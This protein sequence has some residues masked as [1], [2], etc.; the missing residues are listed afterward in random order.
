MFICDI[1][2]FNRYGKIKLDEMLY[3]LKVDWRELI[4][5][6]VIEQMS[7][8]SQAHLIPFLQ[9]DKA[10]VTKLLKSMENKGLIRREVDEQDQRNKLCYLTKQ[11]EELIPDLHESLNLWEEACFN[12]ISKEDRLQF[13]KISKIIT[14]NLLMNETFR[15]N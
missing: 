6:L 1:S 11:G 15:N 9:T 8:I 7:G 5:M 3:P 4:V 14:Q 13:E 10:N 12:G 2:I